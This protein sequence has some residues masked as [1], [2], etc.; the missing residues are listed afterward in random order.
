MARKGLNVT[1]KQDNISLLEESFELTDEWTE[2]VIKVPAGIFEK[3][4]NDYRIVLER[5][6]E[7]TPESQGDG[8][9]SKWPHKW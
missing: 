9:G 4:P 5:I 6:S 1:V 8:D 7:K 2:L 3:T